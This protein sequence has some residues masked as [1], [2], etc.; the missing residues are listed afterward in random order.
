MKQVNPK[1]YDQEYFKF[2]SVSPNFSKKLKISNFHKKYQEIADLISL[3]PSDR[4]CDFGCGNGDLSFLLSLKY[5]CCI[6]AI[7]Y[8]PDAISICRSNLALFQKNTNQDQKIKFYNRDNQH[9]PLLKKIKIVYFCDVFEHLYQSEINSIINKISKWGNPDIIVHT[10]NNLY[11]KYIEPIINLIC[12]LTKK[13]T[14]EQLQQQK[15]FH[16]KRHVNL[17]NPYKLKKDMAKR[18]YFQTKL[19][20][21]KISQ[22]T[23]K[24]QL[25]P[26]SKYKFLVSF[27]FFI[28]KMFPVFF[29]SFY[30]VYS[31]NHTNS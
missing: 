5:N 19:E 28:L 8:S 21:P 15:K 17:T 25:G 12:L 4:I 29:P 1:Y 6:N 24:Q 16:Q 7:D 22:N 10:D 18:G 23:I 30:S 31:K 2:Q 11:L 14:I 9:L 20:Y 3:K 26:L 13:T 27:S